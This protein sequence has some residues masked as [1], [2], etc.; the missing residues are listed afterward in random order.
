MSV[1]SAMVEMVQEGSNMS[2]ETAFDVFGLQDFDFGI[3]TEAEGMILNE[4]LYRFKSEFGGGG[5]VHEFYE[6]RLED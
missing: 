1:G 2:N 5:V 6:M 3:S 4:G